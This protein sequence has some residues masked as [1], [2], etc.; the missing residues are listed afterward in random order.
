MTP[1][2]SERVVCILCSFDRL[3]VSDSVAMLRI[4]PFLLAAAMLHA[5]IVTQAFITLGECG[6]RNGAA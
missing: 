1:G 6:R 4:E 3:A 5:S 2:Y